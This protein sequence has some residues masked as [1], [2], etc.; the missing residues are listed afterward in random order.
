MSMT[1]PIS[2][3]TRQASALL[4]ESP[5]F[6]G[7]VNLQEAVDKIGKLD[8]SLQVDSL[9]NT[10]SEPLR[11][12]LETTGVNPREDVRAAFGAMDEEEFTA[13]LFMNLTAEQ[14]DRYLG[15]APDEAGRATTYR[16]V[17]V[18]HLHFGPEW[19]SDSHTMS[20]AIV[21]NGTIAAASGEDRIEAVVD[22]YQNERQRL[23]DNDDYM[24]LVERVG[25]GSTAW[26]V[27]SNVIEDALGDSTG[28][29]ASEDT[30]DG[31]DG[32]A[33]VAQAGVQQALVEWSNRVL[34]LSE[35][36]S[37][38]SALEGEAMGRVRKL[39]EKVRR[40]A[41]SLTLTDTAVEGNVYLSMIDDAEASSVVEMARGGLAFLRFSRSKF[42][43]KKKE[44]ADDFLQE[45]EVEQDD[46][47]VHLRFT[48][49]RERLQGISSAG[50]RGTVDVGEPAAFSLADR[51]MEAPK[52]G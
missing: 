24:T 26:F 27:G 41:L 2:A 48:I 5:K 16:D 44:L 3:Q 50:P 15:T 30:V 31:E 36:S 45:A 49:G 4:P 28:F 40:Q 11:T 9:E 42:S 6:V 46:S 51:L 21:D 52:N 23:Q 14:V 1:D 32:S 10:D 25:R 47:L 12:F 17:P 13:V 33:S 29:R 18:Y 8:R 34:G 39:K 7:M 22:R 38:V 43:G 35:M 37:G 20:I 19:E